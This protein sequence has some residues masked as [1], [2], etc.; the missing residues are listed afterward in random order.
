LGF[1]LSHPFARKMA[2]GWGTELVLV[3]AAVNRVI[4]KQPQVHIELPKAIP[5][6]LKPSL[7]WAVY[8]T[9]EVV[10]FQ[11]INDHLCGGYH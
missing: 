11:N 3:Q 7:F 9:T 10:P 1:V 5:Q 2:K 6:G 8:G 4:F